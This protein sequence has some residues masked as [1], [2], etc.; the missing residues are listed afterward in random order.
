M[1]KPETKRP[2]GRPR[3]R[4]EYNIKMNHQ[5]VGYQGMKWIWLRVGQVADCCGCST[6]PLGFIICG[7][8]LN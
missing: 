2:L 5:E 4:W 7:E 6:E 1:G 8:F 3:Y